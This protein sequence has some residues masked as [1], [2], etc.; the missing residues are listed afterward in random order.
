MQQG[1]EVER[2]RQHAGHQH[3]EEEPARDHQGLAPERRPERAGQEPPVGPAIVC[4]QRTDAFGAQV[5]PAP[6]NFAIGS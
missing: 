2:A 6:N 4:E 1:E 3:G 5:F